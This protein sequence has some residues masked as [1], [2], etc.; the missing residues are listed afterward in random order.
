MSRQHKDSRPLHHVSISLDGIWRAVSGR[1]RR[2]SFRATI[3]GV[4]APTEAASDSECL[5]VLLHPRQLVIPPPCTVLGTLA[6]PTDNR[7][8]DP[9]LHVIDQEGSLHESVGVAPEPEPAPL[10]LRLPA[11]P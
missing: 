3:F 9:F 8:P 2:S 11:V 10:L 7:L 6:A 1:V 5:L 4:S